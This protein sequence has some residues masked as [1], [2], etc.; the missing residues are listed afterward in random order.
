[1]KKR[2]PLLDAIDQHE[3]DR[4]EEYQAEFLRVTKDAVRYQEEGHTEDFYRALLERKQLRTKI[5][6]AKIARMRVNEVHLPK[7][8]SK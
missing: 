1:M 5:Q 6:Q 8:E 3:S 2:N 7:E 4:L